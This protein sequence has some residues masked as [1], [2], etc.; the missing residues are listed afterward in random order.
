MAD[1]SLSGEI[2]SCRVRIDKRTAVQKGEEQENQ[3]AK[4]NKYDLTA[5]DRWVAVGL[6][7]WAIYRPVFHAKSCDLPG[8]QNSYFI[9]EGRSYANVALG[10]LSGFAPPSEKAYEAIAVLWDKLER[11]AGLF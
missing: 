10:P 7:R 5:L 9:L 6:S 1:A 11:Q 8:C 4:R 3:C 2:I